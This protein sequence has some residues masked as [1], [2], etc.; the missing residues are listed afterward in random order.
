MKTEGLNY[1]RSLGMST[2]LMKRANRASKA[3][4]KIWQEKITDLFATEYINEDGVRQFEHL[5]FFTPCQI[6]QVKNFASEDTFDA[7]AVPALANLLIKR[8]DF[9]FEEAN[10]KSRLNVR[11]GTA[12]GC[13]AEFKASRENCMT[14]TRILRERLIPLLHADLGSPLEE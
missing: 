2:V 6:I 4:S 10:E 13:H 1:L 8:T 9:D 14:L 7:D 11:Y 3:L 5:Y 12:T